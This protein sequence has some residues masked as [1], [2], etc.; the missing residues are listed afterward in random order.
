M[1]HRFTSVLKTRYF[2]MERV[3]ING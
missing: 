1:F 3:S 2:S